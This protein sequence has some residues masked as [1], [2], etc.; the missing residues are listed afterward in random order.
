MNLYHRWEMAYQSPLGSLFIVLVLFLAIL[1][2]VY[3]VLRNRKRKRDLLAYLNQS[4]YEMAEQA[5]KGWNFSKRH[6]ADFFGRET[7]VKYSKGQVGVALIPPPDLGGSEVAN[8]FRIFQRALPEESLPLM[9]RYIWTSTQEAFVLVQADILRADGT[10]LLHLTHY[11]KDKRL[12]VVDKEQ[13][14]LNVARAI[15]ALQELK[16]ENGEA[17]YHGFLLPRSIYLDLDPHSRVNRLVISHAGLPFAIGPEKIWKRLQQLRIGKLPIEPH[18]AR[19]LL[20]QLHMLAPEQKDPQRLQEVGPAA[21]FFAY[22]TLALLLFTGKSYAPLKEI[23][24]TRVPEKWHPFLKAC[25]EENPQL[26][27]KSF[28][29]IEDWLTDPELALITGSH[30]ERELSISTESSDKADR[31]REI[32]LIPHLLERMH[33]TQNQ[34]QTDSPSLSKEQGKL[35]DQHL[36]TGLKAAKLAKWKE[37]KKAFKDVLKL[38]PKHA[39]AHVQLAIAS[40]ELEDWKTAEFHYEQAKELDSLLAK[41]FREHIAFKV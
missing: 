19:E 24:W 16:A 7:A 26:R 37:A 10:P 31:A 17:L 4:Y 34:H 20:E 18:C 38:N 2:I 32:G 3:G 1:G 33:K 35:L 8:R 15:A 36:K 41:S 11:V 21:D 14:L 28:L 27:P 9:A 6:R 22:A 5:A 12:M 23:E 29:E 30:L 25:L 13:I 39:E 40:Y